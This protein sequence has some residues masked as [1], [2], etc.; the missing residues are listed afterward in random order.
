MGN[1]V[2]TINTKN[3]SLFSMNRCAKFLPVSVLLTEYVCVALNLRDPLSMKKTKWVRV[4]KMDQ[5]TWDLDDFIACQEQGHGDSSLTVTGVL[6]NDGNNYVSLQ[7]MKEWDAKHG[8]AGTTCEDFFDAVDRSNNQGVTDEMITGREVTNFLNELKLEPKD[9][10]NAHQFHCFSCQGGSC[11]SG[12]GCF[13]N[14][15]AWCHPNNEVLLCGG[16]SMCVIG[17]WVIIILVI[18]FLVNCC[19]EY[20]CWYQTDGCCYHDSHK[21][22]LGCNNIWAGLDGCATICFGPR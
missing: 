14:K 12:S 16:G 1:N 22:C 4:D 15:D 10:A 2:N 8:N 9:E 11:Q 19:C 5:Q 6:P 7:K 3:M 13:C 18:L 20:G 17:M 21:V